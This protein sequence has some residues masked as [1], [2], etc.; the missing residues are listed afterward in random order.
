MAEP[1][2]PIAALMH[3]HEFIKKVV[4]ALGRLAPAPDEAQQADPAT[5]REIVHF[6]REFADRC[7][8]AKEEDL[9]FPAM[10]AKGVPE[11]GCP[12]GA[13]RNE[14]QQGR[15]LVRALAEATEA[16]AAGRPEAGAA[17]A[18]TVTQI[19]ALY[20]NHI[21]KEDDMVFPMV[22]RLFSVEERS[23]L[24]ARFEEAERDIGADHEALAAFADRLERATATR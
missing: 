24:F 20:T 21:W 2:D 16:L 9:L 6:M 14:H 1:H 23:A 4:A 12:L 19:D 5:L 11:S 7:H 3:E 13:L 15:T 22:D 17:I 18:D 8:H 10:E